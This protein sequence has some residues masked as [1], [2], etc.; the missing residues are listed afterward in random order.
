MIEKLFWIT[1]MIL[2]SGYIGYYVG[3][4]KGSK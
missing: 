3:K 4:K 2:S 1:V